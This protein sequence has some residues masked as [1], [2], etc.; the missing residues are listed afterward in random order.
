RE[1]TMAKYV[2]FLHESPAAW[3]GVSPEE[4]Q[5]VIEKYRAWSEGLA[6]AGKM[7]DGHKLADEGGRTLSRRGGE[8]AVTDGPYLEARE[9]V[10]GLFVVEADGYD[11][12]AE[13]ARGCPHLE[14]GWIELRAVEPT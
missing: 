13:I 8:T 14:H 12:A 5:Q 7:V 11:E 4:M 1:E 6:A 2:L 10:G 3:A 9:V